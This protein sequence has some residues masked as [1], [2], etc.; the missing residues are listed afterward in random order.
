MHLLV[1]QEALGLSDDAWERYAL[2][3]VFSPGVRLGLRL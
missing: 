2:G 1:G 3:D